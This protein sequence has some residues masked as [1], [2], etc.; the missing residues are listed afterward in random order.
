MLAAYILNYIASYIKQKTA[1]GMRLQSLWETEHASLEKTG[2]VPEADFGR[3]EWRRWIWV[4]KTSSARR[5]LQ[6]NLGALAASV[7]TH[8]LWNLP[9]TFKSE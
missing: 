5:S 4:P 3:E 7:G 2:L 9:N 8:R 6:D 1:K